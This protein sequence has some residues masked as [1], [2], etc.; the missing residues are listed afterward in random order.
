MKVLN[1][2][3]TVI[4]EGFPESK[5]IKVKG[6]VEDP[7][8]LLCF[9]YFCSCSLPVKRRDGEE[10]VVKERA[11]GKGCFVND[12]YHVVSF[13]GNSAQGKVILGFKAHTPWDS[14]PLWVVLL[15]RTLCVIKQT[16]IA[17]LCLSVPPCPHLPPGMV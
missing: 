2:K 12:L 9:L 6:P 16:I 11:L 10:H 4:R 15:P 17:P 8:P 13:R 3:S 5:D 14:H 1:L 7:Y